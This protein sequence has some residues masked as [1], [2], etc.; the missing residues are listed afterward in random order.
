MRAANALARRARWHRRAVFCLCVLLNACAIGL[1]HAQVQPDTAPIN[2]QRWKGGYNGLAMLCRLNGMLVH[3]QF[4][5]WESVPPSRSMVIILGRT[6]RLPFNPFTY[7]RNGGAMVVATDRGERRLLQPWGLRLI[8]GPVVAQESSAAFDNLTDCPFAVVAEESDGH[9]MRKNWSRLVT[10]QSGY[11]ELL[12]GLE[13]TAKAT[14]LAQLSSVA[15][16]ARRTDPWFAAALERR[17]NDGQLR[18]MAIICADQSIFNNQM[19]GLEDNARFT[20]QS[21]RWLSGTKRTDVLIIAERGVVSPLQPDRMV[22]PPPDPK[23]V[24]KAMKNLPPQALLEFANLVMTTAED[25]GVIDELLVDVSNEV[26][27]RAMLRFL[28]VSATIFLALWL[29]YRLFNRRTDG[30][31][32][33]GRRSGRRRAARGAIERRQAAIVLLDQLRSDLTEGTTQSWGEALDLL[34]NTAV[35]KRFRKRV[36]SVLDQIYHQSLNVWSAKQLIKLERQV[37]DWRDEVRRGLLALRPP[38]AGLKLLTAQ[39]GAE[40]TTEH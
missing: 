26:P 9:E 3:E 13:R 18:P 11:L 30:Q 25:E 33:E 40:P 19:L 29:L 17:T 38:E 5:T 2:P 31:R 15:S 28:I 12:S 22:L 7:M 37:G 39:A 16:F 8:R 27:R 4:S 20:Q 35:A 10:N 34:P 14:P 21:L 36:Q 23:D 6:N 32:L 1:L 24:V